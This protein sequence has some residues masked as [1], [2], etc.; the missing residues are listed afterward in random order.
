A[1][2]SRPRIPP[3]RGRVLRAS[4]DGTHAR[5][6]PLAPD[7]RAGARTLGVGRRGTRGRGAAGTRA[8]VVRRATRAR[9][10]RVRAIRGRGPGMTF[11]RMR[12]TV[13]GVLAFA[14]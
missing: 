11:H 12:A 7:P 6:R 5:R 2:R 4:R 1:T 8:R 14:I 10:V 13:A 3:S 9:G